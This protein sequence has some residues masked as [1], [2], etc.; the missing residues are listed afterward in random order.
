M[1][2]HPHRT[3][4]RKMMVG[5]L[6]RRFVNRERRPFTLVSVRSEGILI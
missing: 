4:T 1:V 6:F 3:E 5:M 2:P